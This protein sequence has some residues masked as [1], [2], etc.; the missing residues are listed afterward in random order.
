MAMVWQ[1]ILTILNAGVAAIVGIFGSK[2]V[3]S[4]NNKRNNYANNVIAHKVDELDKFKTLYSK[5]MSNCSEV[6]NKVKDISINK[7]SGDLNELLKEIEA[8]KFQLQLSVDDSFIKYREF[9]IRFDKYVVDIEESVECRVV[10]IDESNRN[11]LVQ[12]VFTYIFFEN[13]WIERNLH[14]SENDMSKIYS[15]AEKRYNEIFPEKD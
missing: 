1:A 13:I 14:D 6:K 5:F 4:K 3:E 12:M 9:L 11:E 8:I 15:E 7:D 2:W 10:D